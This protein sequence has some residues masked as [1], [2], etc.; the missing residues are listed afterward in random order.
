VDGDG[1]LRR[2]G[3]GETVFDSERST[4]RLLVDREEL[5]VTW[6]RYAPGEKG[7]DPHVHHRHTDAFYVLEGELELGLG[8][9]AAEVVRATAGT[10]VAAPPEVVHTFRN[11]SGAEAIFLNFHAP[12]M[13][14]GDMLRAR[15]DGRDEDAE[16]FDQSEPPPEGGRPVSEAVVSR[17]EGGELF[18]RGDRAI[19]V[20]SDLP[21]ISAFDIAFDPEFVV[22]P[23]RHDDH[24]DS[25]YVLAGEV[26]FTVGDS[27][28]RAAPGTWYSAPPGFRHGFRNPGPSRARVLN[29]HTPDG[30]FTGRVRGG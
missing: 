9:G 21:Q 24:V 3:E 12:S 20:K 26:D 17:A 22:D 10:F 25:F 14:F 13:G 19:G 4:L 2:P 29:V 16:R 7:P 27:E 23:H 6:F 5:T 28:A 15:R 18:D 1:I 8:P 30:G 11:A